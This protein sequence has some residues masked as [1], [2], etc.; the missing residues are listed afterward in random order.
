MSDI[1][2]FSLDYIESEPSEDTQAKL[3]NNALRRFCDEVVLD[4]SLVDEEKNVATRNVVWKYGS[5][6][7]RAKLVTFDGQVSIG[8]FDYSSKRDW[9]EWNRLTTPRA[10]AEKLTEAKAVKQK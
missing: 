3:L 9:A 5:Y 1:L 10:L 4:E 2:A 6:Q 7:F 8:Q